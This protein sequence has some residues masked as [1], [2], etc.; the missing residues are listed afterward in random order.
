MD[1]VSKEKLCQVCKGVKEFPKS[2]RLWNRPSSNET[3]GRRS[4][5]SGARTLG[6][7]LRENKDLHEVMKSDLN[8]GRWVWKG[9]WQRSTYFI[10]WT[11][12][13]K[14]KRREYLRSWE[15]KKS[16]SSIEIG[17]VVRN[18]HFI[19]SKTERRRVSRRE[20]SWILNSWFYLNHFSWEECGP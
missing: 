16:W 18:Q 9:K 15:P 4:R 5:G 6:G 8:P 12:L 19:D 20:D 7:L 10:G 3:G 13:R 17:C 14:V 11:L 2:Q 1:H